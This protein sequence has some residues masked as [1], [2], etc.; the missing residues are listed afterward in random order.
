MPAASRK[1]QAQPQVV[2]HAVDQALTAVSV[3]IEVLGEETEG[4]GKGHGK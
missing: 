3:T 1:S 4:C 2:V